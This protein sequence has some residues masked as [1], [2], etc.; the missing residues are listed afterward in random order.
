[1]E[2][3]PA[4]PGTAGAGPAPAG[5]Q[6][7]NGPIDPN[8]NNP[9]R[10]IARLFAHAQPINRP[11]NQEA[12]GGQG[13]QQPVN[14]PQVQRDGQQ[15]PIVINY[16]VQYQFPQDRGAAPPSGQAQPLQP[17]QPF[18]GFEGPGGGWQPW[19][20]QG[21]AT[22]APATTS[23]PVEGEADRMQTP[24]QESADPDITP[25]PVSGTEPARSQAEGVDLPAQSPREAAALA[26]MKRLGKQPT[27]SATPPSAPSTSADTTSTSEPQQPLPISISSS[28]ASVQTTSPPPKVPELIPLWHLPTAAVSQTVPSSIPISA[29]A[30]S[31]SAARSSFGPQTPSPAL[32]QLPPSITQEQLV[33]LDRLTREAI[34]ERLRILEGVSTTAYRCI[35]EL[36]RL[37]SALPASSTHPSVPATTTT[38]PPKQERPP[39]SSA[40]PSDAGRG[41]HRQEEPSDSAESSWSFDDSDSA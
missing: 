38:I 17:V 27:Q 22:P 8:G 12:Q 36:M 34:D 26:A 32:S 6:Q 33:I 35:D 11:V 30:F 24:A 15:A 31:F 2:N 37:R 7:G 10:H 19:P 13:R 1:L 3:V 14:H 18:S 39:S 9:L 40:G 41:K 29:Q 16:Q 21:L 4:A 23:T 5:L 20:A 28:K 25:E